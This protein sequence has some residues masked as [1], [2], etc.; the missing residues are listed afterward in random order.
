MKHYKTDDGA[1]FE[2]DNSRD[3]IRQLRTASRDPEPNTEAFMKQMARRVRQTSG[4]YIPTDSESEFVA[5]LLRT[6]LL[7]EV[8][9]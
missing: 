2:A 7:S 8:T 9:E 3:V 1:V 4:V 5:A 6:G